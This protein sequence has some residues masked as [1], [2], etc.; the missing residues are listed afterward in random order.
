MTGPLPAATCALT[1]LL[2]L[3][4]CGDDP[5]PAPASD[6]GSADA[7][8]RLDAAADAGPTRGSLRLL[9]YNVAGLP[10]GISKSTPTANHPLISPLLNP[11]DLVLAQEDFCYHPLLARDA[12]HPHQSPPE[13][14]PGCSVPGRDG[15][16]GDGL[17]RFSATP[18]V[19]LERHDWETCHGDATS[20][21]SD[22]LTR[23]GVT[24]ARHTLAPGVE[25]DVYNLHMEAGGCDEDVV[26]RWQQQAQLVALVQQRSAGRAVLIGGDTNLHRGDP[27]DSDVLDAILTPLGLVDACEAIACGDDHIDRVLLR[28]SDALTLEVTAWQVPPEFVDGAGEDLSDHVP[29]AVVIDWSAP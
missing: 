8:A 14:D 25:V 9:T 1:L 24:F 19:D 11:W 2:A 5:A 18:F 7:T 17:N 29:V 13:Y 27:S 26:A 3:A 4:A 28:S 21:A 6:G 23:K 16:I 12:T 15:D 10:E 20:C 22:C